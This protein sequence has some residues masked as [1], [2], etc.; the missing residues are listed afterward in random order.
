VVS[1]ECQRSISRA[2]GPHAAAKTLWWRFSTIGVGGTFWS[3]E[4]PEQPEQLEQ[5]EQS[6]QPEQ[7]EQYEQR[8]QYK[9][10]KQ[11]EHSE[12]FE[13]PEQYKQPKQP[14][15]SEQ[16]EQPEQPEQFEQ[17]EQFQQ[18]TKLDSVCFAFSSEPQYSVVALLPRSSVNVM[19]F[20]SLL[21]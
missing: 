18:S 11:P 6:E 4:Q 14:E 1:Q 8:E 2:F 16:F 19:F 5:R 3:S 9:Q 20:S 15:H 10:P 17:F 12:Q 21:F 13:Q 7:S